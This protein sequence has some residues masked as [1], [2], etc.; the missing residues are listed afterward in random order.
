MENPM[1][2]MEKKLEACW[3][4]LQAWSKQSF[5]NIRRMLQQKKKLLMQAKSNS[6]NGSN[7]SQVRSL[8]AEVHD[9]MVKEECLW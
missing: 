5:S 9:L 2:R 6:M 8:R 4:S 7:H 3:L 1:G